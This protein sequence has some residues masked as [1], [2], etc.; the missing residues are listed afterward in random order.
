MLVIVDMQDGYWEEFRK[1]M[2]IFEKALFRITRRI[3]TAQARGEDTLVLSTP[4]DGLTLPEIWRVIPP[5]GRTIV[6]KDHF[7]GADAL[8]RNIQHSLIPD[9]IE[10]VGAFRDVCVLETWKGLRRKEAYVLPVNPDLTIETTTR[11]KN[12]RYPSGYLL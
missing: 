12:K 6:H 5:R 1:Q 9:P 4:D 3:A 7:D 8:L 2:P 10:L 11:W